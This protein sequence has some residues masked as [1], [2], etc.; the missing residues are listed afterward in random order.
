MN[1]FSKVNKV[2]R[3]TFSC[4]S[5]THLTD[6]WTNIAT[7]VKCALAEVC[8]VPVLLVLIGF[9]IFDG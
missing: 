6:G 9:I 8:S 7:L 1:T 3:P 4:Q 2:I 5:Q